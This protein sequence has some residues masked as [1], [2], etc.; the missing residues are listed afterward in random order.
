MKGIILSLCD[1]T[2]NWSRPYAEAGYE[3][4][5]LD[6]ADGHDVRLT[7]YI[8]DRVHGILAAPPCQHFSRAGAWM[9]ES[10]GDAALLDGLSIVDACL[11]AVAIYRPTWWAL[12]NP[13]GRIS[14]YLGPPA[15]KFDP[16]QFAGLADDPDGEAYT[17][18]TLLWGHFTPPTP[19]SVGRVV[20][21]DVV[22]AGRP[23]GRDRTTMLGSRN[24]DARSATP[25]G[26]ARAFFLANP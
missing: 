15:W 3:V 12:E 1:R 2:G 7:E 16:C 20:A 19:L 24:R 13:V 25:I 4:R 11:R 23:G 21:R 10:K 5:R 8:P 14:R 9:W 18:R 26:F 22:M 6:L 17:K